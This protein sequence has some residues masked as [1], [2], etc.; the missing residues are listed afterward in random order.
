MTESAE[1]LERQLVDDL[2]VLG[3]QLAN[4]QLATELYRSLANTTWHNEGGHVALSWSRAEAVVNQLRE[5]EG[6]EPLVLSQTGGEGEVSER[7]SHELERLGWH[8]RGQDTGRGDAQ[9]A[10]AD[11]QPPPADHGPAEWE[12]QAHAEADANQ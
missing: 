12:R 10:S 5:R 3:E 11:R 8:A 7:V 4:D 2:A 6:Q 1:A 9:H